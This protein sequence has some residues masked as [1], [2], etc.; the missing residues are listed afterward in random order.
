MH[1]FLLITPA[2]GFKKDLEQYDAEVGTDES[3]SESLLLTQH[4]A[5]SLAN[6]CPSQETAEVKNE[7]LEV[8]ELNKIKEKETT[9]QHKINVDKCKYKETTR[10]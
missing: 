5:G 1:Y 4:A 3:A 9:L 2:G 8:S 6:F 7:T 10:C